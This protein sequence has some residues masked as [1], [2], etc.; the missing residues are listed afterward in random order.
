VEEAFEVACREHFDG[1]GVA[2]AG[3][4]GSWLQMTSTVQDL[5]WIECFSQWEKVR[6]G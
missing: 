6:A 2:C 1:I 3:K 4:E 5:L